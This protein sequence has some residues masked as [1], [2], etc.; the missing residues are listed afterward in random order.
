MET[1]GFGLFSW[2]RQAACGLRGHDE[3]LRFER[4]RMSLKCT[5]CGHESRGWDLNEAQ[6]RVTARSEGRRTL[7]ARPHL[8]GARRI[9]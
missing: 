7:V 5:S 2:M 1:P 4:E 3:M 6:P 9:A 8:I